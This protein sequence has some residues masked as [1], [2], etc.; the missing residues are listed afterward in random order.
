M[1]SGDFSKLCKQAKMFT[2][3]MEIKT[4]K[5]ANVFN[6]ISLIIYMRKENLKEKMKIKKM[7]DELSNDE[8]NE[9]DFFK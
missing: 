3:V 5:I 6:E 4:L 1:M 7:F 2:K 9:I 8:I